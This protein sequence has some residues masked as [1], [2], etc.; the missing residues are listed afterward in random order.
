[1]LP[2]SNVTGLNKKLGN[3]GINRSSIPTQGA[4]QRRR[5]YATV[6]WKY[7][8][9]IVM[10]TFRKNVLSIGILGNLE[11]TVAWA[12]LVGRPKATDWTRQRLQPL[13]SIVIE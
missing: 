5:S 2:C 8:S 6:I 4:K 1:M 11:S 10:V 7:V 13:P 3:L 9:N 12:E